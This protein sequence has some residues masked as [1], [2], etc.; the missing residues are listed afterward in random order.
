MYIYNY[1]YIIYNYIY[2]CNYYILHHFTMWEYGWNEWG[3]VRDSVPVICQKEPEN[4]CYH[5]PIFQTPIQHQPVSAFA[6]VICSGVGWLWTTQPVQQG[7]WR[8][9]DGK[10]AVAWE[11]GERRP[12][13]RSRSEIL[14]DTLRHVELDWLSCFLWSIKNILSFSINTCAAIFVGEPGWTHL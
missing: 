3:H 9:V 1:I 4:I 11:N 6:D 10:W 14:W 7:T 8:L 5:T 13:N 12:L 2:I